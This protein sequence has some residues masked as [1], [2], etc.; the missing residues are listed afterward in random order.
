MRYRVFRQGTM[1]DPV[2]SPR[3]DE[4]WVFVGECEADDYV[5]AV[6]KCMDEPQC[7]NKVWYIAI[8]L[9]GEHGDGNPEYWKDE[10]GVHGAP[11]KRPW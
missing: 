6:G 8:A 5:D 4:P 9:D 2:V 10:N 3:T 7:I 11:H 1:K